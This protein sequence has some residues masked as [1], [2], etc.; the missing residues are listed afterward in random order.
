MTDGAWI[1][2]DHAAGAATDK[3]Q[4]LDL[5]ILDGFIGHLLRLAYESSFEDFATRLGPD[6]MKPAYFSML[7]MIRNNP[8]ITQVEL[9]RA[10][11]RDKSSIAK[12][13]RQFEDQGLIRRE[14]GEDDRRN[15]A[16]FV[17]NEGEAVYG[18]MD[19]IARD[20][21]ARMNAV[22]GPERLDAFVAT[23]HD[24]IAAEPGAND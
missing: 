17:T 24:L 22:V 9:G 3:G 11:G 16:S 21:L 15:Y 19:V 2:Q 18:R 6:S 1:S 4:E 13:L 14:R 20:H 8:G 10:V 7:T 23:L 12:A 5:G